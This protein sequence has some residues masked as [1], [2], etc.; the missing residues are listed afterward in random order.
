MHE[1]NSW[2]SGKVV[3]LKPCPFCGGKPK[4][5]HIGNDFKE[6]KK[7]II[8][9]IECRVERTDAALRHDFTWL[10]TIATENWNQRID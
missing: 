9:C 3:R 5:L 2:E 4:L 1:V 6:K 10:E 8:K 7:I